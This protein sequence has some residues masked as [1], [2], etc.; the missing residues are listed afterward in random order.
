MQSSENW[1]CAKN[2]N[3]CQTKCH[4]TEVKEKCNIPYKIKLITVLILLLWEVHSSS[5]L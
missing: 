1:T 3:F 4:T 5:E 2:L